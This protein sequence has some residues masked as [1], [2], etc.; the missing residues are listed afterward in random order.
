VDRPRV[1]HRSMTSAGLLYMGNLTAHRALRSTSSWLTL[2]A[3][4]VVF[5][6]L[7]RVPAFARAT[8]VPFGLGVSATG[9]V[10]LSVGIATLIFRATGL[11]RAYYFA[12]L[13]EGLATEALCALFIIWS[14]NVIH[15]VWLF[16]VFHV[17]LT[18]GVGVTRRNLAVIIAGPAA[19]A[20]AFTLLG[21]VG[22]AL[23]AV[24]GGVIG[25][26]FYLIVGRTYDE[27][28]ASRRR[29][30]DLKVSL[31][32]L[33]VAQERIRIARDLHDGVAAEL[34]ALLWRARVLAHEHEGAVG[35]RNMLGF[36]QRVVN[37]LDH[38][39]DVVLCLRGEPLTWSKAT[40][41][42]RDRCRDLCRELPLDFTAA[43]EINTEEHAAVWT[44][45][46]HI[47]AELV[48][49]AARHAQSRR[50]GVHINGA[51]EE[52]KVEVLDD[53]RGMQVTDW[54][55]SQGGLA[56]VRVRTDAL[57][58]T[59]VIDSGP[60]GTRVHIRVPLL[61]TQTVVQSRSGVWS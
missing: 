32:D 60:S 50:V 34:S 58:G 44:E 40:I 15:F 4:G 29:E 61:H 19:V 28:E 6:A 47:V 52:V 53:G 8:G 20:A 49:N 38:L 26:A 21:D 55:D 17:V 30:A 39:R 22:A 14:R 37:A 35:Q 45:V 1:A 33:Q 54:K 42:L 9:L 43:G 10:L 41:L 56:N 36:E 7:L 31:G 48:R 27:L 59:M 5:V 24:L 2:N 3:M 23:V 11:S 57:M 16:Y 25:V 12:D 51:V 13:I 18:A 46:E